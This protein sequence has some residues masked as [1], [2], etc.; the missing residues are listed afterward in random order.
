M[1]WISDWYSSTYYTTS[2]AANPTGPE[3]GTCKVLRGGSWYTGGG[4]LS[5]ADRYNSCSEEFGAVDFGFRCVYPP[6]R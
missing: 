4:L 2:P 3:S 6:G 1:E 5:V